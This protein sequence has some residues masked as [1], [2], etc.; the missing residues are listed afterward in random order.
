MRLARD[1]IRLAAV[2]GAAL[3]GLSSSGSAS[4]STVTNCPLANSRYSPDTP[5]YDLLI[6]QRARNLIDQAGLLRQLPPALIQPKL[7]SFATIISLRQVARF[8]NLDPAKLQALA[9][10]LGQVPITPD[11]ITRRCA[12]YFPNSRTPLTV[13]KG[14]PSLLVF[15]HS[16]GFRD[17]PSVEAAQAAFAAMAQRRDWAFV[18][19]SN[20][21]DINSRNLR[22]FDGVL[23]NNVS[24]DVLT[25][26]Q[27]RA[28]RDY[29]E[30]GGGFAAIHG[31]GGDPLYLW[32]WYA[33]TL[34]GAR[35]I[36]HVDE[37]QNGRVIV[38]GSSSLTAGVSPQWSMLEEWYSFERSPRSNPATQV[39]LRLDETS[40]RPTS[41]MRD[42]RMG[43]HPIAWRRCIGR[44]RSVYSAIGHRPETYSNRDNLIFLEGA[45]AWTLGVSPSGCPQ[46]ESR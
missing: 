2:I 1:L 38:E 37:H 22:Q 8:A 43:D 4:A 3:A 20:P 28:L 24:G 41:A 30:S 21:G 23:W 26:R 16:T 11:T 29:V 19:T 35:F 27:R 32:D 17:A 34:I 42:L 36:G 6:D 13:P 31:S 10:G 5:L 15:E 40:Y 46:P 44:G 25:L 9:I 33:D 14:K 12:R 7:P 18:F 39:L 45:L